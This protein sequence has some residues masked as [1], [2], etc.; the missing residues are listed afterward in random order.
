MIQEYKP[1]HV[2]F[3]SGIKC[4]DYRQ[5][6]YSGDTFEELIRNVLADGF[7]NETLQYDAYDLFYKLKTHDQIMLESLYGDDWIELIYINSMEKLTDFMICV[8][9]NPDEWIAGS[10]N[11]KSLIEDSNEEF[12]FK[13]ELTAS[14]KK[15]LTEEYSS[16]NEWVLVPVLKTI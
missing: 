12:A 3:L 13:T 16:R 5:C 1:V 9:A 14:G 11:M 15:E 4:H 8:S 10:E 2:I 6:F 7:V